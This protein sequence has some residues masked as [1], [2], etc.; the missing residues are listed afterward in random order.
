[1]ARRATRTASGSET[2]RQTTAS[3]AVRETATIVATDANGDS[4]ANEVTIIGRGTPSSFEITVDGTIERDAGEDAETT[5][6]SGSTIEG[7]IETG[8]IRFGFDGEL[9]DVTFVDRTI[10]GSTPGAVPNVHVD[11]GAE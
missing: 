4:H 9:A 11:Y 7:T 10:A 5:L 2:Q 1:M 3:D 6:R 8:T